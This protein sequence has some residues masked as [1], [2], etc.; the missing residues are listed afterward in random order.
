M[1]GER[2]E[3]EVTDFDLKFGDLFA[4]NVPA[5][6]E[7]QELSSVKATPQSKQ[8]LSYLTVVANAG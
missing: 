8:T 7:G 1:K 6:Y 3:Y 2:P 4:Q 5:E